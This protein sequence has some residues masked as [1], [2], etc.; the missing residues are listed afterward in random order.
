MNNYLSICFNL[1]C[2]ST[3]AMKLRPWLSGQPALLHVRKNSDLSTEIIHMVFLSPSRHIREWDLILGHNC[4]LS[5]P[6]QFSSINRLIW[7]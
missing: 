1:Y 6:S 2:D 4:S 3:I 5:R 7:F